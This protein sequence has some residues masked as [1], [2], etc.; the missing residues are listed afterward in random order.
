MQTKRIEYTIKYKKN[1]NQGPVRQ[2]LK[3]I[4]D[5]VRKEPDQDLVVP[6]LEAVE[7]RAT[8]QEIC[9]VMREASEFSIP[10]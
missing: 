7:A 9:D 8:L 1:R 4:Y 10:Q 6:I 3:K 2:S 5:R